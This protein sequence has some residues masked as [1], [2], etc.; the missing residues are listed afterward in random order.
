MRMRIRRVREDSPFQVS[1]SASPLYR[2]LIFSTRKK[3]HHKEKNKAVYTAL[4]APSGPKSES[5][6]DG[7][8]DQPTDGHTLI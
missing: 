7:L 5:V 6:T 8:T 2:Y 1:T 4:V 3:N